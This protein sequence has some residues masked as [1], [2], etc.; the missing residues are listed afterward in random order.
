MVVGL[1]DMEM[2]VGLVS[3]EMMVGLADMKMVV[4]LV[5]IKMVVGSSAIRDVNLLLENKLIFLIQVFFN[6]GR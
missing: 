1:A 3:I 6:V 2:V 4:D 5:D